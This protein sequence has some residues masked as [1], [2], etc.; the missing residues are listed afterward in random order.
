MLK[1][2][3]LTELVD[4]LFGNKYNKKKLSKVLLVPEFVFIFNLFL[5][6]VVYVLPPQFQ[7]E[8]IFMNNDNQSNARSQ[9]VE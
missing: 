2:G 9:N 3:E 1:V 7:I 4:D 6:R 8:S 5:G